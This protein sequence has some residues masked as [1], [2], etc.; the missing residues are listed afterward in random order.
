[1]VAL[2]RESFRDA[3]AMRALLV[4]A[5]MSRVLSVCHKFR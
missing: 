4:V 2:F 3:T 5:A 1:M